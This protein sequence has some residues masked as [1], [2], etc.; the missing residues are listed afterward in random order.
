M[1]AGQLYLL[2]YRYG[3]SLVWRHVHL[4]LGNTAGFVSLEC[5]KYTF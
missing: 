5:C 3:A 4:A 1:D 2:L